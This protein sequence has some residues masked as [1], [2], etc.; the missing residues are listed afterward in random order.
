MYSWAPLSLLFQFKRA[1]NIYF[2]VISILTAQSFSPKTPGSMIGTFT[3]VL[4]FTMLKEAYEDYQRYKSDKELNNR[5][6][7]VFE[8]EGVREKLWSEIKVGEVVKVHKDEEVPADLLCIDAPKDVVFISTM[9]LDGETNLK[10]RTLPFDGVNLKTF[11]GKVV[12]DLPSESLEQWDGNVHTQ[13]MLVNCSIK[14]TILRGCT[15]K[16]TEY[17]FGIVLYVGNDTKIMLNAKKAPRKVSKLMRLMNY[18]LYTVFAFQMTLVVVFAVLSLKWNSANAHNHV[19]LDL[20]AQVSFQTWLV[21]FFTYWV[22]YSHM[23]PISLYVII[24]M[25]KLGQAKFINSDVKMFCREDQQFA[26]CRNS[27]LVEELG[28]VEF[29]FS[30]KTGTLTQNKME[31][32][33]ITVNGLVYGQSTAGQGMVQDEVDRI[34]RL[35]R[36]ERDGEG[37]CLDEF[38][39]LLA[40]C[41]TVVCDVDPKTGKMMY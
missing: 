27:D 20:S 30:D 26:L 1:A 38:Y 34:R 36:E 32:K 31:F 9:N 13:S 28:Q 40:V 10:E 2:L 35:V 23:I 12:C 24:E 29:V 37:A 7:R 15:L 6:T 8:Q 3:A 17:C 25:L 5:G 14:N 39:N 11:M 21:Q 18:M 19:Y 41:H 33:K 16:N 4:F 22:A